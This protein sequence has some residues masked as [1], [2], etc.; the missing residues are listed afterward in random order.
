MRVR[1]REQLYRHLGWV[2]FTAAIGSFLIAAWTFDQRWLA[3]AFTLLFA[4]IVLCLAA[5][6]LR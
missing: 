2:V 4:S 6:D 1:D 5:A 3:T